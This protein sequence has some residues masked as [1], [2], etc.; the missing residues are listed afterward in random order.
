[1]SEPVKGPEHPE[2]GYEDS[3]VSVGRLFA[4]AGGSGGIDGVGRAGER[5]R[6]SLFCPAPTPGATGF[7]L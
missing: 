3:D 6:V 1:M 4:F 7:T 5:R 2:R